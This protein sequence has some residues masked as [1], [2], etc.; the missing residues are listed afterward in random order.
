LKREVGVDVGALCCGHG[1]CL[2]GKKT[3]VPLGR[4]SERWGAV[5]QPRRTNTS[6]KT[7]VPWIR[8]PV[9]GLLWS[10]PVGLILA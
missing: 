2:R 3:G 5:E 7:G 4:S 1:R 6:M 9:S 8:N 10:N